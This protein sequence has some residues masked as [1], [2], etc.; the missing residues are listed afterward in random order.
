MHFRSNKINNNRKS[1]L[2]NWIIDLKQDWKMVSTILGAIVEENGNEI[3][4]K[5]GGRTFE[6]RIKQ[7]ETD[8]IEV[9]CYPYSLMDRFMISRLRGIASKVGFCIGCKTCIIIYK[10]GKIVFGR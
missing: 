10:Y 7:I 3:I 2:Q 9:S 8:V 4:Q 1:N 6:F 5:I